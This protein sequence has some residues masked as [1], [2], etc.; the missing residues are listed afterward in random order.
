MPDLNEANLDETRGLDGANW[1]WSARAHDT[2]NLVPKYK[3][4]PL[5]FKT[6]FQVDWDDSGNYNALVQ[7]NVNHY[8]RYDYNSSESEVL[9]G[10]DDWPNLLYNFT[11]YQKNFGDSFAGVEIDDVDMTW[12]IAQAMEEDAK[13]MVGGP[14][15]PVQIIDVGTPSQP[16][17][18]EQVPNSP[19]NTNYL[20]IGAVIAAVAAVVVIAMS[21]VVLRKR[22]THPQ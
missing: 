22:K 19:P 2:G 4:A 8:P 20:V 7:A 13:N 10:Y 18:T 1:D 5:A 9:H 21:V 16:S 12:E 11:E 3:Y 6:A 17:P 15:G 14:T